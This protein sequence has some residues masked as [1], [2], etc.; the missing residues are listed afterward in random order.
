MTSTITST[1]E[2]GRS[3][4]PSASVRIRASQLPSASVRKS[5]SAVI[6]L[7]YVRERQL[8]YAGVR[9]GSAAI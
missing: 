2:A 8:S 5:K 7:V 6:M 9:V 4:L 1:P 3:Q